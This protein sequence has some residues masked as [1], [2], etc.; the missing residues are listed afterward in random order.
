MQVHERNFDASGGHTDHRFYLYMET[1][2]DSD[3]DGAAP[4]CW[5][6]LKLLLCMVEKNLCSLYVRELKYK[7]TVFLPC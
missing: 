4:T 1:K 6:R 2:K 5:D 3:P 7:G